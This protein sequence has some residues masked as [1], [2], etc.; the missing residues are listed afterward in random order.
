MFPFHPQ[1]LQVKSQCQKK[2]F[3][4][5]IGLAGAY[6]RQC[7]IKEHY[8]CLHLVCRIGQDWFHSFVCHNWFWSLCL[9]E[10][11]I[12]ACK[13]F[14]RGQSV[15]CVA[16]LHAVLLPVGKDNLLHNGCGFGCYRSILH[17]ILLHKGNTI[18]SSDCHTA[19]LRT[20]HSLCIP[21]C[22]NVHRVILLLLR[23]GMFAPR[24]NVIIMLFSCLFLSFPLSSPYPL[25][26]DST[27][28]RI[29]RAET[30]K[31]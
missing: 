11:E 19:P 20:E 14:E 24:N 26:S 6:V 3:Y 27:F 9:L 29:I 13:S 7:V 23:M 28:L 25:L 17:R 4:A 1:L 21:V 10:S 8:R 22:I 15:P 16:I 5:D 18:I 30:F 31:S 12:F 2:E